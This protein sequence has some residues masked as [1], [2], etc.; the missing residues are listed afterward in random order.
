MKLRDIIP[1]FELSDEL[2]PEEIIKIYRAIIQSGKDTPELSDYKAC[3][4]CGSVDLE[5]F[6]RSRSY[7]KGTI[8][9]CRS[10]SWEKIGEEWGWL[11]EDEQKKLSQRYGKS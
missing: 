3:P 7:A 5:L 11:P 4:N 1:D 2:K 10:C 6:E 9:K 8:L